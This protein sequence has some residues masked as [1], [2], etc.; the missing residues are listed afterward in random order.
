MA[1]GGL[2]ERCQ[3]L[4]KILRQ[5]VCVAEGVTQGVADSVGS[6]RTANE[7]TVR[8]TEIFAVFG[9]HHAG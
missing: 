2:I 7:V 3:R 5:I 1:A 4:R 9:S 8:R 6:T